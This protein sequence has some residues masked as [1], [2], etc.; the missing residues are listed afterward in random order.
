[1]MFLGGGKH[2]KLTESLEKPK[3]SSPGSAISQ[4]PSTEVLTSAEIG[5]I[6]EELEQPQTSLH[7]LPSSVMF[8][9]FTPQTLY[10]GATWRHWWP[11]F[12]VEMH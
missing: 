5:K 10:Y 12:Y 9:L 1:M 8:D 4:T 6:K 11:S 3:H 2:I 7:L